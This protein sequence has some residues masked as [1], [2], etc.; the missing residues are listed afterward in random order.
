MVEEI[1]FK[2]G[3]ETIENIPLC[4]DKDACEIVESFLNTPDIE[5]SKKDIMNG[6]IFRSSI[7]GELEREIAFMRLDYSAK[8]QQL[9]KELEDLRILNKEDITKL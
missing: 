8:L 7:M 4:G 5:L 3:L 9:T 2:D 1:V 6:I